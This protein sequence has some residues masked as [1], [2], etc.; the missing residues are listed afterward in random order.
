MKSWYPLNVVTGGTTANALV[1][2]LDNNLSKDMALSSLTNN[3]GQAIYKDQ[4]NLEKVV[5][6][7]P[8]MKQAKELQY[9]FMVLDK[10]GREAGSHT[11]PPLFSLATVSLETFLPQPFF[12]ATFH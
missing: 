1:K 5:R 3:I 10:V 2:G 6:N 12:L 8:M 11:S 9:G 7:M 4:E